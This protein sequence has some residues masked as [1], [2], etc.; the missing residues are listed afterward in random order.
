MRS[1]IN[2]KL[3]ETIFWTAFIGSVIIRLLGEIL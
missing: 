1:F 2:S 3:F